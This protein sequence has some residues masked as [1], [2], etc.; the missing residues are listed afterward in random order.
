MEN[1]KSVSQLFIN[2]YEETQ[3]VEY[4]LNGSGVHILNAMVQILKSNE[5]FRGLFCNVVDIYRKE[6]N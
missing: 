6:L 5:E 2:V 3:Q 1:E 4:S